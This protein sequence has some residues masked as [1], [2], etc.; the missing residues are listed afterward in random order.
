MKTV[1]RFQ[2]FRMT[3]IVRERTGRGFFLHDRLDAGTYYIKVTRIR[4]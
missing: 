2:P 3:R 4:R 1:T